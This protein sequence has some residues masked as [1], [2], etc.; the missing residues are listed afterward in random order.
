MPTSGVTAWS[1]TALSFI[2]SALRRNGIISLSE[3]PTSEEIAECLVVF[4]GIL[5]S[6]PFGSYLLTTGTVIVP[7]GDP[8]GS[9]PAG[10][11]DV[12]SARVVMNAT[13]Q[14]VLTRWGRSEYLEMPNKAQVGDP[15]AFYVDNQR[16]AVAMYVWPVPRDGATLAIEYN[17]LPETITDSAQT[18]DFPERYNEYLGLELALNC[19][20]LF[21]REPN[22][23]LVARAGFLRQ[24]FEDDERPESYIIESGF[25]Y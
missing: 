25:N 14:R 23:V 8:S 6:M 10:V 17:R 3:T 1:L 18:V 16:D 19:A 21:G 13:Y 22:P 9:L 20:G 11:S 2:T 15:M 4:N 5:K 24:Q 12:I 7:P